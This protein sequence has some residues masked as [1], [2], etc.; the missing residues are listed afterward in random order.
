MNCT[1]DCCCNCI[2]QKQLVKHPSNVSEFGKG[3]ISEAMGWVCLVPL[4]ISKDESAVYCEGQHDMCE[5][6]ERK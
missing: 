3:K 4:E 5:L 6:H 1:I 2:H